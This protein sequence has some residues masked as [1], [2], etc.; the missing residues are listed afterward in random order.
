MKRILV[1]T[2]A[3]LFLVPAF[4]SAKDLTGR[5]GLGY[6]SSEAPVG[7]RYWV[8]EKV[9]LDIGIGFEGINDFYTDT[10]GVTSKE[11]ATSFWVEV[12]APIIVF[13]SERANFAVRPGVVFAQLDDRVYGLG[14]YDEK[15]T[16]ITLSLM[17]MAEVFFGDHFSLE[18]GHG[19]AVNILSQP[20]ALGG[21]SFTD[22][23][24][25]DASITHI[26]FH[27]YFK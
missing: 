4:S 20:D 14:N 23:S 12:G 7:A 24:T 13:P 22:F 21:E 9:G 10:A 2:L 26:G 6:F 16:Q 18:A 25:F 11:T 3:V 8:N 17:P 19:I 27:F 15:W 5:F 1:L